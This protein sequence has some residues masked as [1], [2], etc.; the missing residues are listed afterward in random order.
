M[1]RQQRLHSKTETYHVMM[2]GNEKKSLFLDEMDRHKY[3]ELLFTRKEEINLSLY[4]FCLMDNHVHILIK[5]AP[6]AL[7]TI[8]K[9]INTSYAYYFNHKYQRVGH[10]F[11]DRFKSEPVE[12]D[13]YLLAAVRY[14]HNN[15]VKAKLVEKAEH[16]QWSSYHSYLNPYKQENKVVDTGFILSIFTND[17][18]TAVRQFVEFSQQPDDI[19]F[20]DLEENNIRTLGEGQS[21]LEECLAGRWSGVSLEDL[22]KNKN[23]RTEIIMDLKTNTALSD[24]AIADL[25]GI[26]RGVVQRTK[27]SR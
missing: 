15:P 19:T 5:A 6:E 3:L 8:M 9:R 26:N 18:K 17:P 2:R 13:R 1:P 22:L 10:L 25:L 12:D 4:A 23:S 14:I 16:Y 11:Q 20:L 7:A 24:R 21:Y 27:V